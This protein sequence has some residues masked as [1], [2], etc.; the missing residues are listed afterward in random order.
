MK[1][2]ATFTLKNSLL[3][4][5]FLFLQY[6]GYNLVAQTIYADRFET[7]SYS[8][9]VGNG[10]FSSNWIETDANG[11]GEN[12]GNIFIADGSLTF[13]G[14][15]GSDEIYREVDLSGATS[16][17]VNIS[18]NSA[19]RGNAVLLFQIRQSNGTWSTITT[20]NRTET[21]EN[22]TNSFSGNFFLHSNSAFRFISG[23]PTEDWAPGEVIKINIVQIFT[24]ISNNSTDA[25][26]KRPFAPRFSE[27]IKGD[28]TFIANTTIGTD[29]VVPYNGTG[30][31]SSIVTQFIDI[32]SDP[33]TFNSSNAVLDNPE[34][35][36]TCL[37]YRR[38]FLYWAASN[39]EYSANTGDGGP[40]PVWDFDDVKLMLPGSSSYTTYTAD[41]VIYNGRAE[42]FENDPIVL[43]KDITAD[44]DALADPY[45]TYQV[46]NVKGAEGVL[47]SHSGSATG[48]SG[49]W[50]IVFVYESFDLPPKNVT[51]FDGYA[52]VTAAEN[53]LDIDFD[54][55]QTIPSGPVN[56][57]VMIGALEGDREIL[58]DELQFLDA[59]DNW[60]NLSTAERPANNFF[61]SKITIDEAQFTNRTPN[62][63]NTLGFDASLFELDNNSNTLI[64]NSQT[65]ATMRITSTQESYGMYLL[66][67]SVE[68]FE[69][70]LGSFQLETSSSTANV[71]PGSTIPLTLNFENFGNDN[72]QNLAVTLVF[73]EQLDFSTITSSP[74]GTNSSYDTASRTLT[75]QIP[76]GIS[77]VG[78]SAYDIDFQ[79]QVVDPCINC[80]SNT[81]IQALATYDG[82][83]NTNTI[84]TLSSDTLEDCGFGNNDP[85]QFSIEPTISINDAS[86]REGGDLIFIISSSHQFA[87]D[88]V[89]N[90]AYNDIETS[91][92]DYTGPTTVTLPA[93]SSAVTFTVDTTDDT[94]LEGNETFQVAISGSTGFISDGVGLGSIIDD[95]SD[96]DNDNIPD[97]I[98]LD[99]DNDGILDSDESQDDLNLLNMCISL[100]L[101]GLLST[102]LRE[103]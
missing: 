13:S 52:H 100:L 44:V 17:N 33:T 77:D 26:V 79:V 49:G 40:E 20:I 91:P 58:G 89:F 63:S 55:F 84:S 6:G 46:A 9:N 29:P 95:D 18:Y 87:T 102:I 36:I 54:G 4:T 101:L 56:A 11:G 8:N 66:G 85:L 73:P 25:Q 99:N 34:A 39:K 47:Q 62:S 28:F 72:I 60:V 78:D 3:L 16:A 81:G 103:Y 32:D 86:T 43:F 2:K 74:S 1:L 97:Q 50:Q 76:N 64:G 90:L 7:T 45:G 21:S 19:M 75:I 94:I 93:N 57:D 14:L 35:S 98:D 38:V 59:A 31:N 61:N 12:N 30:G 23:T 67:L 41:E 51:L 53:I 65:R 68:V 24:N 92:S 42:H 82:Q 37:N 88:Q 83:I 5:L 48:T 15:Q 22:S 10:N 70:N 80:A 71:P 96:I 27:N 69:P